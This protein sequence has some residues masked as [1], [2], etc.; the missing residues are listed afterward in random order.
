M[1]LC[2]FRLPTF[3]FFIRKASVILKCRARRSLDL[4]QHDIPLS[5]AACFRVIASKNDGTLIRS[6]LRLPYISTISADNNT[7]RLSS[8]RASVG[9]F[10]RSSKSASYSACAQHRYDKSRSK[11]RIKFNQATCI[12]QST[13]PQK[14][15]ISLCKSNVLFNLIQTT[16]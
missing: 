9:V 13:T 7:R 14:F 4:L 5:Q 3:V 11:H 12:C 1:R 8:Q 6:Y 10:Q 15:D 16:I 2:A